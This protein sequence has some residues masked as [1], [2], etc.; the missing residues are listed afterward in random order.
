ME[1]DN[2]P[3]AISAGGVVRRFIN[4]E[5]HIV[6]IRDSERHDWYLPKGHVE[7]GESL[8]ETATREVKEETGLS[9]VQIVR[10][11]GVTDRL[12][13]EKDERKEI[14]YFLFDC[15]G[16]TDLNKEVEDGNSILTP[17]WF[18]LKSLPK[19]FWQEQE[20]IIRE[21]LEKI[22]RV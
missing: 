22:R 6:L 20:A 18:S 2:L 15:F 8:K 17:R 5:T 4:E 10:R 12:S 1:R 9:K 3:K 14:H 13:F 7:K 21:T 11:L 16:N 19:M